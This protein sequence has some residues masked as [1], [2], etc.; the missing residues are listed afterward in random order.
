[1]KKGEI[2]EDQT[3]QCNRER[4]DQSSCFLYS[5]PGLCEKKDIPAGEFRWLTVVSPEGPDDVELLLEPNG[6]P[7]V[8]VYQKAG[9]VENGG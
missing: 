4:S 5:S 9:L 6:L 1:V 3:N 8:N 7:A 2:H